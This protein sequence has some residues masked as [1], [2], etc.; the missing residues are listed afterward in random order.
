MVLGCE[1]CRDSLRVARDFINR[2]AQIDRSRNLNLKSPEATLDRMAIRPF[3]TFLCLFAA[4]LTAFADD[5]I[6]AI[7]QDARKCVKALLAGDYPAFVGYTHPRVVEVNGG[8]DA[9]IAT[10]KSGTAEM[11]AQ[12]SDLEDASVGTPEKPRKIGDW[13]V[14]LVPERITIK[15]KGGHLIQDSSLLGIS[16][17]EGKHWTFTDVGP[18]AQETF[19][20]VF[21]ELAGKITLP[22]KKKP[23]FKKDTKA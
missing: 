14:A 16:E 12:G 22:Q 23:V 5:Q 8:K 4:S 19:G 9:M 1:Q 20:K 17:D 18:T 10:L 7:Q 21:P 11:H 15:V 2:D 13:L 3:L 6:D